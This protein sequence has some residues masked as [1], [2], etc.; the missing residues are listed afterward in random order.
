MVVESAVKIRHV[1][2]GGSDSGVKGTAESCACGVGFGSVASSDGVQMVADFD[3]AAV[4]GCAGGIVCSAQGDV[5]LVSVI[6]DR[7]D[8]S[9]RCRCLNSDCFVFRDGRICVL[10]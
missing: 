4:V 7:A 6:H 8:V 5:G 1:A 9:S 10:R 2:S 3:V